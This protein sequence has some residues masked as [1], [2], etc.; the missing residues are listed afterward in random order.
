MSQLR[1]LSSRRVAIGCGA[2]I[3]V[4]GYLAM[5]AGAVGMAV[6]APQ[7]MLILAVAFEV[8]MAAW[9]IPAAIRPLLRP[10]WIIFSL[11]LILPFLFLSDPADRAILGI[12]YSSQGVEAASHA[13]LRMV[14]ILLAVN[15]FTS[16]VEISTLA[17]IFEKMGLH[18]LG[19]SMG[20]ALNLLPSLQQSTL[21][22]YRVL[23]MRGGLRRQRWNGLRLMAITVI[24]QALGRAEE[25]ALAAEARA[26]T[27][28][29]ASAYP[30]AQGNFDWPIIAASSLA[31]A[32]ALLSRFI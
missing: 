29:R 20:V 2:A 3:G 25:I 10:R 21:T 15:I 8:V 5:L 27:P 13:L 18:G 17:G 22:T 28:E 30:I 9:I 16:M 19:F 24:T 12:G 26:F 4:P 11:I 32:A 31:V 7:W 23:Q 14:G 6:F 1:A